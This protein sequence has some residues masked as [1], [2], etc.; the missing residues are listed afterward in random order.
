MWMGMDGALLWYARSK[1]RERKKK[2]RFECPKRYR[3]MSWLRFNALFQLKGQLDWPAPLP[4]AHL[5]SSLWMWNSSSC[6][7]LD[8]WAQTHQICIPIVSTKNLA[9][10]KSSAFFL[11]CI[12][13]TYASFDFFFRSLLTIFFPLNDKP[14]HF[15][16]F[17]IVIFHRV[18]RLFSS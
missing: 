10:L 12:Q 9:K 18:W 5:L 2:G 15:R 3:F 4:G 1:E 14:F 16:K 13:L 8:S 17:W 7:V 11:H 6:G